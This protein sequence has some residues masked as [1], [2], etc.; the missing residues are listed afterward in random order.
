MRV[1]QRLMIAVLPA[2]VGVLAVAA[3][4]Y[5]GQFARQAPEAVIVIAA[6]AAVGSLV[7]AW[8]NTR[9]VAHRVEQLAG[10]PGARAEITA[11][12]R[13][14]E[15]DAIEETVHG[16]HDAV[17]AATTDRTAR[18]E[19]AS[20]R[21]TALLALVEDLAA[22]LSDGVRE[23]QLPLH[24]LL[25]SPFGELNENQEEILVAARTAAE[26]ADVR[27]RQVQRLLSL[28]RGAVS[29]HVKPV[30]VAELMRPALAIAEARAAKRGVVLRASIDSTLPRVLVDPVHAQDAVTIVLTEAV[31]RAPAGRDLEVEASESESGAVR[32]VVAG[33]PAEER[34]SLPVRL[35]E[36]LLRAQGGALRIDGGALTLE[37]P[38]EPMRRARP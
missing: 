33:S 18:E 11:G 37:L 23:I 6:I 5:W 38:A 19:A 28:E 7:F 27:I 14:D 9:Y 36:R 24:I 34:P 2:V 15:L 35:A 22:G 25:D 20:E 8:R 12:Q 30:G 26:A 21:A 4:A 17:R 1:G 32:L 29:M 13:K 10:R 3:L 31:E 16:L